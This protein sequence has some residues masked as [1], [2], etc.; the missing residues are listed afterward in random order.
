MSFKIHKSTH[1]EVINEINY[2][3]LRNSGGNTTIINRGNPVSS[4]PPLLLEDFNT[5]HYYEY[6]N[7]S[8]NSLTNFYISTL[9]IENAIYEIRFNCSGSTES[10]NDMF[11]TPNHGDY[12]SSYF[13][14]L[15]QT[16]FNLE[17][18][19]VTA[20]KYKNSTNS[21]GFYFDFY[22]GYSGFDPVGKITIYNRRNCKKV[23]FNAGDTS[24]STTG[25]GYWLD[26]SV[27][28]EEYNPESAAPIYN[29]TDI[30]S[31]IGTLTFGNGF[32]DCTIYV[33]R[34]G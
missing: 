10:N 28:S 33:S 18:E 31:S 7:N 16:S 19:E 13:Y 25:S 23:L 6:E 22:D 26:D 24:S 4:S 5:I 29:T 2:Y 20:V 30:W 14:T 9:M 17:T 8:G 11:F 34:V 32:T 1:E 27:E 12:N 15:F 3:N 21:D